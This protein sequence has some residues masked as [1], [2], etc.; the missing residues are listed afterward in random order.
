MSSTQHCSANAF[1]IN[2]ENI[3]KISMTW[4]IW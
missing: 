3:A 2:K 1:W 4:K